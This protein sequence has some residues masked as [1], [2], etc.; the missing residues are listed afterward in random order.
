MQPGQVLEV[1]KRV[2]GNYNRS[3]FEEIRNLDEIDVLIRRHFPDC[4]TAEQNYGLDILAQ[5]KTTRTN[6]VADER[7]SLVLD[8]TDFGHSVGEVE[9]QAE[10]A[11]LAHQDIDLFLQ[12]YSWFCQQGSVE[13]KL[14]AYLRLHESKK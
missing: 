4:S 7:F 1:K 6:Y 10:D 2:T 5:F 3:V 14:S 12:K 8:D 11:T 13:G 9:L